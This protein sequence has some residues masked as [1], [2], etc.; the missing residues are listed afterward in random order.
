MLDIDF[1]WRTPCSY[2]KDTSENFGK[3]FDMIFF[4]THHTDSCYIELL[5]IHVKYSLC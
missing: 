3:S 1:F 4:V 2:V 5:Q